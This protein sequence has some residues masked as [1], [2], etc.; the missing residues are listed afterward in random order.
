MANQETVTKND[1][2]NFEQRLTEKIVSF[3]QE[4]TNQ[5]GSARQELIDRISPIEEALIK[6]T[7][8][9][10]KSFDLLATTTLQNSENIKAMQNTLEKVVQQQS[11][12]LEAM[13]DYSGEVED[14]RLEKAA[15]DATLTQ[16]ANQLQDHERR[17]HTLE[18]KVA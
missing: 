13:S 2:D 17:I 5:I 3:R 9:D 12:F 18:E 11:M 14:F 15:T 4:L 16:Q 1:L 8:K 10:D 7:A 6:K